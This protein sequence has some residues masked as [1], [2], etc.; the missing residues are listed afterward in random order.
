MPST[1][2]TIKGYSYLFCFQEMLRVLA[3]MVDAKF[4]KIYEVQIT[5]CSLAKQAHRSN[6]HMPL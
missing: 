6:C 3:K 1:P 2:T 5:H 4:S